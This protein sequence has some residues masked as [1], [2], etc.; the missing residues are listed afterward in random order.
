MS[1]V[2]IHPK[3]Q[4]QWNALKIIF[5]AMNVPFEQDESPYNPEFVARIRRSEEQ[6]KAGKVT[7]V[8]KADLQSFL[9]LE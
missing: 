2:I 6:I 9:G 5:E 8:E 1:P 7:R 3:D 4:K